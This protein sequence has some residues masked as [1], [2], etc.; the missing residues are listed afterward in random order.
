M[1]AK[2]AN[3]VIGRL[4]Q[5]ESDHQI[6]LKATSRA[7]SIWT[8]DFFKRWNDILGKSLQLTSQ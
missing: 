3:R 2:I 5:A 4:Q 1:M 7:Y 8:F 6:K